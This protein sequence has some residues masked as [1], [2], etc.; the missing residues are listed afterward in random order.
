MI[1][2]AASIL[3]LILLA[4]AAHAAEPQLYLSWKVPYGEPGALEAISPPCDS[5][6]VDTLYLSFDPGRDAPTFAGISA[7]LYFH[8][9]DGD[10]LGAYWRF[11]DIN[12]RKESPLRVVFDPDSIPGF[13]TPWKSQGMGGPHYDYVPGSGRIRMIYA[14]PNTGLGGISAGHRYGFA[15]LLV[16]HPLKSQGGCGQPICVEWHVASLGFGPSDEAD[17]NR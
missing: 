6:G 7:S 1:R 9:P 15:R 2:T 10:S 16:R 4:G 12:N 11:D 17:V 14:V 3:L 5:S 8:A 13:E